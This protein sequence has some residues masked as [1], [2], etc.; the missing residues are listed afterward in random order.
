MIEKKPSRIA[1]YLSYHKGTIP[2]R[3]TLSPRPEAT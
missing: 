2:Y 3:I 1:A